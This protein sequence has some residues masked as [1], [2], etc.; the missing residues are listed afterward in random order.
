MN[1][2]IDNVMYEIAEKLRLNNKLSI[3]DSSFISAIASKLEFIGNSQ[4]VLPLYQYNRW[5]YAKTIIERLKVLD[6]R[7]HLK[8]A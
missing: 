7:R 3:K 6:N 4:G 8:I 5:T 1:I 2:K